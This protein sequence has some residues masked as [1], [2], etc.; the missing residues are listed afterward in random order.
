MILSVLVTRFPVGRALLGAALAATFVGAA[1]APTPRWVAAYSNIY[2]IRLEAGE[3]KTLALPIPPR[4]AAT[5]LPMTYLWRVI[6]P[7]PAPKF[8]ILEQCT[9][10]EQCYPATLRPDGQG[11]GT[12]RMQLRLSNRGYQATDVE[13]RYT[14]WGTR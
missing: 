2:Q 10:P 12:V 7:T 4:L 9:G 11:S 3:T 5:D 14:I 1:P 6:R 8:L 13:F